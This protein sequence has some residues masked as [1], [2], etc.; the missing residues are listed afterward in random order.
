[1]RKIDLPDI[2]FEGYTTRYLN[3][4]KELSERNVSVLDRIA[5]ALRKFPQYEIE[6]HG[7][8]VSVL[9]YDEELSDL[10]QEQTLLPLSEGRSETIRE[11]MTTRGIAADRFTLEW[12]GKL[13][14]LVPFSNLEDRFV[15]RRVEFYLI[16]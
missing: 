1:M 14:P 2:I 3:W 9:Y 13:R 6:L 8:A 10:E 12:W 7:H 11:A 16:R 4:N 15:D 5:G